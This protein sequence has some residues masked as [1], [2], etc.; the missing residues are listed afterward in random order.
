M[1]SPIISI[2]YALCTVLWSTAWFLLVTLLLDKYFSIGAYMAGHGVHV[3]QRLSFCGLHAGAQ[4]LLIAA[5]CRREHF[6][7][8]PRRASRPPV[9]IACSQPPSWP[10]CCCCCCCC[11]NQLEEAHDALQCSCVSVRRWSDEELKIWTVRPNQHRRHARYSL[12][13]F[14][15]TFRRGRSGPHRSIDS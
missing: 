14:H 6:Y 2:A 11:G 7:V 13:H 8:M 15:Q 9:L 5:L 3:Y 10:C 1:K 4:Y 12:T